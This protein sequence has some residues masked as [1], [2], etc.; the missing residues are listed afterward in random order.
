MVNF[1]VRLRGVAGWTVSPLSCPGRAATRKR[2]C[3]EPGP[4]PHGS[5]SRQTWAPALQRTAEEALRCVRG[6]RS[7]RGAPLRKDGRPYVR[8]L[9]H[10]A[11]IHLDRG[12][13]HLGRKRR[14][15]VER[16]LHAEIGLDQLI[17]LLHPLAIDPAERL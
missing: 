14:R 3:A 7:K 17:V 13:Q 10:L 15:H 11:R 9:L 8:L 12:I 4:K 1:S 16:L 5:L 6:T 2:C